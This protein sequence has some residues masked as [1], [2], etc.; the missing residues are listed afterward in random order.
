MLDFF[1]PVLY[2]KRKGGKERGFVESYFDRPGI[3]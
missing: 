3:G 1:L 2:F